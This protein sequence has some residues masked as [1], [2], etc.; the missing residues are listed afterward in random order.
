MTPGI[1]LLPSPPPFFLLEWFHGNYD[2]LNT[3]CL[4]NSILKTFPSVLGHFYVH[5]FPSY[6]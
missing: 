1:P 5:L 3:S 4:N 2:C 6:C